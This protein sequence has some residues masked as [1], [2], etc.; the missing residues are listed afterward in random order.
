M[1][2]EPLLL[3]VGVVNLLSS[4]RTI[5]FHSDSDECLSGRASTRGFKNKQR[6]SSP[7]GKASLERGEREGEWSA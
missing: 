3:M 4:H 7:V 6:I 5:S 1:A 2:Y